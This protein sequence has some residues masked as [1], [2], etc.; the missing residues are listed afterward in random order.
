LDRPGGQTDTTYYKIFQKEVS[1]TI[2]STKVKHINYF[3]VCR[4]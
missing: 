1:G 2:N 4:T 3:H